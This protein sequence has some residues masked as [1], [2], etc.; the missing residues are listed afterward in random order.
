[1]KRV[2]YSII[3]LHQIMPF[4]LQSNCSTCH[5]GQSVQ[6]ICHMIKFWSYKKACKDTADPD[7]TPFF[8]AS[9]QG[10]PG[11][12]IVANNQSWNLNIQS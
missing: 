12:R 3:P 10:L 5:R 4:K 11:V 8:V 1:M 9:D 2:I 6:N 7:Q